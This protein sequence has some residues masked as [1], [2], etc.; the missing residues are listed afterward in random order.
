MTPEIAVTLTMIILIF[1]IGVLV[2]VAWIVKKGYS[3]SPL[4]RVGWAIMDDEDRVLGYAKTEDEFGATM[5]DH[6]YATAKPMYV[7]VD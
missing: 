6:N 5:R 2:G 4:M 1:A 3:E 7:K